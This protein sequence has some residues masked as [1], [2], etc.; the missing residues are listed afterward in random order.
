MALSDSKVLDAQAGAETFGSALMAAYAG[1]NSVS[2]PGMLDYV[3]VFNLPK[4]VFDDE[5]CGQALQLTQEMQVIEDLPTVEL[6]RQLLE[7]EHLITAPHTMTHWQEQLYMPSVAYDRTN[8]ENWEKRGSLDVVARCTAEVERRLGAYEPLVTDPKLKS[9]MERLILAGMVEKVLPEM[10][11]FAR[12]KPK[13]TTNT[14]TRRRQR[15]TQ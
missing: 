6:A 5:L 13:K 12:P 2:G 15:K 8:R 10:P 9:E 1:I 3:M 14:R 4:L 11:A 7:E